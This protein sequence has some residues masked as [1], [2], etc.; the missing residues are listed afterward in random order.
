MRK[1]VISFSALDRHVARLK[2]APPM[3]GRAQ[4]NSLG[5]RW[6]EVG[7]WLLC[8]ERPAEKALSLNLVLTLN[9]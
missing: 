1:V 4:S 2:A 6:Q 3:R 7:E 5:A 8:Q 9:L